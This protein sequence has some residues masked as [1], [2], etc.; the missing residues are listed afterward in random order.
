M[1]KQ[2]FQNLNLAPDATTTYNNIQGL[3]GVLTSMNTLFQT[4]K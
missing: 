1:N 3:D 2:G 4:C